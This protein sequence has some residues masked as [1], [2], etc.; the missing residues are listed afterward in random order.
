MTLHLPH[1]FS[2]RGTSSY[3]SDAS[4]LPPRAPLA[5]V[6]RVV[7]LEES[8]TAGTPVIRANV[9][10]AH[11]PL[12]S[13]RRAAMHDAPVVDHYSVSEDHHSRY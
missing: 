5:R 4:N 3:W 1:Y 11:A 13:E 2:N 9:G 10:A 6:C 12:A 8:T 7:L